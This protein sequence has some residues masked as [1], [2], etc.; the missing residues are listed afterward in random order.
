MKSKKECDPEGESPFPDPSTAK[1]EK[2][3]HI[4]TVQK[5]VDRMRAAGV[6]PK[7]NM[8]QFEGQQGQ[9]VVEVP[10]GTGEDRLPGLWRG[11]L[12]QRVVGEVDIVIPVRKFEK[13]RGQERDDG[14]QEKNE[15]CRDDV[16]LFLHGS[17]HAVKIR[18]LEKVEV[19]V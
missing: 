3:H 4:E 16:G 11:D 7:E 19:M 18:R 1:M 17:I 14:D 9:R 6:S 13:D 8:I 15:E 12:D 2:E 10:I 5:N